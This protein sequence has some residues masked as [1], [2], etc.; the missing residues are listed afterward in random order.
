[1]AKLLI[2]NE[3]IEFNSTFGIDEVV[4]GAELLMPDFDDG[5]MDDVDEEGVA[6]KP[7]CF[8]VIFETDLKDSV[9]FS[10]VYS[11]CFDAILICFS[12]KT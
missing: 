10:G 3:F 1:M 8:R 9:C 11:F 12:S 5:V 4:D 7:V 6:D 2:L